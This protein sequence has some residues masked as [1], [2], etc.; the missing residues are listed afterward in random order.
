MEINLLLGVGCTEERTWGI[1]KNKTG[2]QLQIKI[3]DIGD[4]T[5]NQ[6]RC[7]NWEVHFNFPRTGCTV[8]E[9]QPQTNQ[10]RGV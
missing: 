4:W 9:E 2:K 3:G 8:T 7:L 10:S 6:A 1:L 5:V